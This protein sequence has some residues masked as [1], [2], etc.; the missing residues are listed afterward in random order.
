MRIFF[1]R[2]LA[3]F[4]RF[5]ISLR[6]R[7][8]IKGLEDISPER[9]NR[10]GGILFMPNHPAHL[11]PILFFT[12]AWPKYQMRPLVIEHI[13]LLRFLKP[14]MKM[15]RAISI[16]DFHTSVNEWKVKQAEKAVQEIARG[17]QRGENFALY[18]AGRLKLG[19]KELLGGS[20]SAHELMQQC[21]D[22][23]VVLVRTSG[24]WGSSFSRALTGKSP[25]LKTT[26]VQ[27]A[28]I[29]LKNL[30]FFTP[31]RKV[32]VEFEWNPP[33]LPRAKATR[34]EFNRFLENW[35]NRYCDEEGHVFEKEPLR[36]VSYSFW[37]KQLP[38]IDPISTRQGLKIP[39][40]E[41]TRE[42][43]Y[44]AIRKIIEK[45]DLQIKPEQTL[46]YDLAMDSLNIA[47]FI[48]FL[49]K[50]FDVH[51]IYP[52]DLESVATVL[53]IAEGGE[54]ISQREREPVDF[55]WP[56]EANRLKPLPAVGKTLPEAFLHACDRMGSA[57]ACG[58]DLIGVLSYKKMKR[59]VLVLAHY[60][61]TIPEER[62]AVLLPASIG[63]YIVILAIQ[64]AGKT[65]VMLNWTLGARYLE[66]MMKL[67]GAQKIITSL[68]FLDRL[69]NVQ[70]GSCL[71]QIC[72]LEEI[73][74]SLTLSMKLKGAWLARKKARSLI[75]SFHL[76]QIDE[77]SPCVILFTSGTEAVP[78]GV[79]LS[80][81]NV[82]S[83][84][85]TVLKQID[86]RA[87]DIEYGILPPFHSFGFSV[88]GLLPLLSGM[89]IAFYPDP[90]NSFALAEGVQRWGITLFCAAPSF[91]KGLLGAAQPEQLTS[92]R[93]LVTGAEKAPQELFDRV[94]NLP[95]KPH[96]LEGYG[97]TECSPVLTMNRE[98]APAKGVGQLLPGIELITIH[99][100]TL[101]VQ[102][103]GGEGE[104]CVRGPN[105]FNG[106]LGNPRT[107]FIE[108]EGKQWY[109]TGDLGHIE[110]DRSVI[111]S[112]RL[113]RFIKLG[114]EMISLG[115]IEETVSK[116]LIQEQRVSPDLPSVAVC[117]IEKEAGKPQII[118]FTI[119]ALNKD[120]A[121][122]ILYRARFSTLVKI[123]AVK[124]IDEIPLMGAGKTNYRSLQALCN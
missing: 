115:A 69:S 26:L 9:L 39:I 66:E 88:A 12:L 46:A 55:T 56:P 83:N 6:Y 101:V 35:Y 59:A 5:L 97:I 112:G 124:Q 31:R 71:D 90:T 76:D 87:S 67:S 24:L 99:P 13:F 16:P 52:D 68:R 2:L 116:T 91:L 105:V 65:P 15:V 25:D 38:K 79:P 86:L 94:K 72:V 89:R 98:D 62:I 78:K 32:V 103:E 28:K 95:H 51:E 37:R 34:I 119:V 7:L 70:F 100:E 108:I 10:K 45:P 81:K 18:P 110:P 92:L 11:D 14:L 75:S 47:E 63:V 43:I 80:H 107:P 19:P 27:N 122:E 41:Q 44:Q 33:G 123:S 60:F 17:L 49:T 74:S 109:R 21:P 73:R 3:L 30:L 77:N 50:Q 23:N 36:L 93:L 64:L 42:K 85:Q 22:T 84:Q 114:G 8:E 82:I 54:P 40:S 29:L 104:I 1:V 4:S 106:Y 113:K 96:L 117:S 118:L 120:E 53:E 121:N 61:Q 102:P 48:S 111:V 20:A 58:D 57:S